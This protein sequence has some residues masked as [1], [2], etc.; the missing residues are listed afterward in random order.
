MS[1]V[2]KGIGKV[3][4]KVIKTVK[5]IAVPLLVGAAVV[6]TAGSALPALGVAT[7]LPSWGS[8]LGAVGGGLAPAAG[9]TQ[10]TGP[11]LQLGG[12]ATGGVSPALGATV[13]STGGFLK[14]LAGGVKGVASLAKSNPLLS[15]S[16][17]N[18]IS[19]H[20]RDEAAME[21][22]RE[23]LRLRD[24]YRGGTY[25]GMP[26]GY[27][28]SGRQ[29]PAQSEPSADAGMPDAERGVGEAFASRAAPLMAP[30]LPP[31][32]ADPN[33]AATQTRP[34]SL[35]EEE[36]DDELMAIM[37]PQ[38]PDQGGYMPGLMHP[39]NL[40]QTPALQW[41]TEEVLA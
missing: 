29:A 22:Q 35:G 8:F 16:L 12:M 27:S 38:M 18:G 10:L 11:A 2:I 5:K 33:M 25:Y 39:S 30:E 3:F 4:K 34:R 28:G 7:G 23:L 14:A 41:A 1:G 36:E 37:Q 17:A 19:S 26:R 40:Y 15:M 6:L 9:A 31:V 13:G 20:F 24:E 32:V 21:R